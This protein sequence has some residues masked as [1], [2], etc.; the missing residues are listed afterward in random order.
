MRDLTKE[1]IGNAPEWATH[2]RAD[3]HSVV[4]ECTEYWQR[5]LLQ[6]GV[7]A[8]NRVKQKSKLTKCRPIV[9]EVFDI[10]EYFNE[11]SGLCFDV[12]AGYLWFERNGTATPSEKSDIIAAAKHFKLT[13]RDLL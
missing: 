3:S 8:H 13:A 2:Y 7:F 12:T 10:G 4:F 11:D 6:L 1:E 5:L 9:R